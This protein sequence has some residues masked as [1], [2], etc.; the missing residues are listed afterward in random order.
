MASTWTQW[1][2]FWGS[3]DNDAKFLRQGKPWDKK[4]DQRYL[5][6]KM[7]NQKII[8]VLF[9]KAELFIK[10]FWGTIIKYSLNILWCTAIP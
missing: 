10:Y 7:K 8:Y 6:K 2:L 1:I 4:W 3:F 9:F 5:F